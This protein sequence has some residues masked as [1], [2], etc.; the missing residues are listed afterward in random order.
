M[1]IVHFLPLIFTCTWQHYLVVL[2]Y[3]QYYAEMLPPLLLL[4]IQ[5][6]YYVSFH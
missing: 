2:L 5:H 3:Y 4:W 1:I 6:N